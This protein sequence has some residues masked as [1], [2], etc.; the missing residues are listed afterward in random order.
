MQRSLRRLSAL[1]MIDRAINSSLDL[2]VTLNVFL[3]QVTTQL[4]V[5][6]VDIL[7]LNVHTNQLEYTAGKGFRGKAIESL[8]L[9]LGDEYAGQVAL[10]RQPISIPD[11]AADAGSFAKFGLI[12]DEDFA[13]YFCMPLLAK[14]HLKGVLE[15]FHRAPMNPDQEWMSF[16]ES[17]AEQATIAI[18]NA[19]L[20]DDMQ[21]SNVDLALA[22]E[23]TIEGWSHALDLRDKE[24]EGHTQ[25]AVELT[26][27]LAQLLGVKEE[28]LLHIRRGALLHD[29]GKMG[30][31]DAVLLKPGPLS[32]EERA[33]MRKH[34]QYAL[35]LL[36]P[37]GYL[38]PAIDIPYAHH[39]KWDGTGYPRGLKGEEI[40]FA[41]RIFA[42][43]DVWDALISDRPY[44]KAWSKNEALK[45]IRE[46]S[47]AHFDPQVVNAFLTLIAQ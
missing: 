4:Q 43:V 46:Q 32:E 26:L 35:E 16:L 36:S 18:D 6:A 31:S 42:V 7:L 47:G 13:S 27:Q 21:R 1:N 8:Q 37:I 30:V 10:N 38:R 33:H 11:L 25:R 22:Y 44:R 34:P 20:F 23:A 15:V 39:E 45:Y 9:N 28:N 29:I 14:G 24:T 3:S 2:R 12:R 41:A 40:P 5:D 19:Q 17:L